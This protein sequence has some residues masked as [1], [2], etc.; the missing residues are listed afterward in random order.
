MPHKHDTKHVVSN[1]MNI[2]NVQSSNWFCVLFSNVSVWQS[3]W[4]QK[5]LC[6]ISIL[7]DYKDD[8]MKRV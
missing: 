1:K 5:Y 7:G 8:Q 3:V 4:V 6:F 2:A